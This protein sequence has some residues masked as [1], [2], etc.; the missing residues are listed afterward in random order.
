MV[1]ES[2]Y[3]M[4]YD[5]MLKRDAEILKLVGDEEKRCEY[6]DKYDD[7]NHICKVS[8]STATPYRLCDYQEHSQ[9]VRN[10]AHSV[11]VKY[12]KLNEKSE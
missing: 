1:R 7:K 2:R 10:I 5:E 4:S 11:D 12:Q 3:L 6:C 8:N 9:R